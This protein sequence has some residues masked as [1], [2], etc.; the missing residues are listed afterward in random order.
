[1]GSWISEARDAFEAKSQSQAQVFGKAKSH[2][3]ITGFLLN[4]CAKAKECVEK[5][6]ANQHQHHTCEQAA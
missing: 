6:N 4:C 3:Q 5:D 2:I 1:M